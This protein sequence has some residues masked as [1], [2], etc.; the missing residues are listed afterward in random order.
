MI[1]QSILKAS[2]EPTIPAVIII[3]MARPNAG[4]KRCVPHN[5]E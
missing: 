3:S 1:H 2:S 4:A 5:L